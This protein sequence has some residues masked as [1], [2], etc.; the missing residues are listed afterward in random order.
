MNA[1]A[2]L[3]LNPSPRPKLLTTRRSSYKEDT[4][5]STG[6][7]AA[8]H[9]DNHTVTD[10]ARDRDSRRRFTVAIGVPDSDTGKSKG[11][12]QYYVERF[13]SKTKSKTKPAKSV[14]MPP[15]PRPSRDSDAECEG[16]AEAE[17]EGIA[18]FLKPPIPPT[19]DNVESTYAYTNGHDNN[20][21]QAV[22][23][24]RVP[25]QTAAAGLASA[26][27][28]LP[29]QVA[30]SVSPT[31]SVFFR[32]EGM[33]MAMPR[34]MKDFDILTVPMRNV[35]DE[36][37]TLMDT[38]SYY[39]DGYV[40]KPSI[41]NESDFYDDSDESD[42]RF[43]ILD[44]IGNLLSIVMYLVDVGSDIYLAYLYYHAG[45]RWLFVSTLSF[46]VIPAMVIT[47]F[48]LVSYIID[49]RNNKA[50]H[51]EVATPC[52][53]LSRF[54]FLFFQCGIVLRYC[55]LIMVI[56]ISALFIMAWLTSSLANRILT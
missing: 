3:R 10:I 21:K 35:V 54:L 56:M 12:A 34:S 11:T 22:A 42:E 23:P 16:E 51:A 14:S 39:T 53:W 37:S 7:T 1:G 41:E 29:V 26:S 33:P 4:R 38:D 5:R 46:V 28:E 55:M 13:T 19:L 43:T 36:S 30:L 49:H 47:P 9:D 27:L 20:N 8:D 45:P 15:R 24:R 52:K 17:G 18:R 44:I 40:K 2:T 50:R 6:G 32:D 25:V 31:D 48:S